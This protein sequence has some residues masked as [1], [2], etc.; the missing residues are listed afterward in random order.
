M[1]SQKLGEGVIDDILADFPQ[2]KTHAYPDSPRRDPDPK[3]TPLPSKARQPVKVPGV[4][5]DSFARWIRSKEQVRHALQEVLG[6][7]K[8][9]LKNCIELYTKHNIKID[10]IV[11]LEFPTEDVYPFREYDRDIENGWTGKMTKEDFTELMSDINKNGITEPG[12]L[13]FSNFKDGTYEI[14][15][16][17][18]NHRLKAAMALGLKTY[19]LSFYYKFG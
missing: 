4:D 6:T 5:H 16:G 9:S 15:L 18:G 3:F 17:E 11:V 2:F 10:D 14:I 13:E 7:T 8:I 19:P 1:K 12:I